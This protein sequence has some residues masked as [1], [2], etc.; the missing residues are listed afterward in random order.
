MADA[1]NGY[2]SSLPGEPFDL[3]MLGMGP[4]GHVAS[5]FPGFD[6]L[7][8]T[9]RPCVEVFGSPKPPP[10]RITLTFPA[11]N[12]S[13]QVWFLVSGDGKAEAVARAFSDGTIDDTPAVG[14]HGTDRTLWLLDNPAASQLPASQ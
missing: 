10:E 9:E 4:D 11:L 12:H 8:E 1:A 6:Q 5:L 7:H 14:A 3:V 2:G 13:K